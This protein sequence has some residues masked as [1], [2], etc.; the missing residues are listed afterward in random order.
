MRIVP[1]KYV[2]KILFFKTHLAPWLEH[3]EQLGIPADQVALLQEQVE[4][5]RA[6][7]N[8]RQ[9][10][11]QAAETA[12]E[13][14]HNAV[15][16][17]NTTGVSLLQQIRA[18][19]A[20]AGRD[21]YKMAQIPVPAKKSPVG[22]PGT[23][24]AFTADL[25]QD[26]ALLLKW[27]CDNPPRAAGTVYHISRK[28]THGPAAGPTFTFLAVTGDRKF[29]D[30]TIPAGTASLIYQVQAI[31]STAVGP[32]ATHNVTF[33]TSNP[34]AH[35]TSTFTPTPSTRKSLLVAA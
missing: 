35:R 33:G 2:P 3:A 28:I 14:Y 12:T 20:V 6:R 26:G 29:L 4:T 10:A 11:Q 32:I 9:A 15:D 5:A 23:P 1:K 18:R 22:P 27:N 21:I 8:A 24:A 30:A 13:A 19:G 17:M 25:H 34:S 16:A 7:Y 31:R